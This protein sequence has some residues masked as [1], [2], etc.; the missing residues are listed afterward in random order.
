MN[1]IGNEAVEVV[2]INEIPRLISPWGRPDWWDAAVRAA[3]QR[4]VENPPTYPD[5]WERR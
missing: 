1:S 3:Q 5:D 2:D 4:R